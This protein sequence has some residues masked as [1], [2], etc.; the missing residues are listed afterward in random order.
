MT[1]SRE[2]S[3]W[4]SQDF[5]EKAALWYTFYRGNVTF[6]SFTIPRACMDVCFVEEKGMTMANWF[7]DLTK[8]IADDKIGRRTAIR[9]VAGTVVAVVVASALP[10]SAEARGKKQCPVGSDCSIDSPNCM[11]NPNP[12]C[13]C[14]TQTNGKP[15]CGCNSYCSQIP[16][17][18]SS[19]DCSRGY[20]CITANGCTGCGT[21][22]GVCVPRCKGKNKNCQL[23]S[24]HGPTAAHRLS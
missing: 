6:K 16:T 18:A 12:N 8:T 1:W 9:R 22:S 14:F 5:T 23:G 11:Y 3:N 20:T 15:V 21:S 4:G 10:A 7:D 13:Y 2:E 17:C 24:G 19:A